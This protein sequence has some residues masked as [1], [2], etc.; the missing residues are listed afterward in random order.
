MCMYVCSPTPTPTLISYTHQNALQRRQIGITFLRGVHNF[1][2][3]LSFVIW[4]VLL[5]WNWST[6]I[7][8]EE[9]S[10]DERSIEINL[11]ISA[12]DS[13]IREIVNDLESMKIN[14]KSDYSSIDDFV[15]D[16]GETDRM[17]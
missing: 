15:V 8:N 1:F 3:I 7:E 16:E 10:I 2:F 6:A 17:M 11:N 12:V 9:L 5:T 14:K 13:E 4:A